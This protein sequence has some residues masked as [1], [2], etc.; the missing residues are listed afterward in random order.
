MPADSPLKDHAAE[1]RLFVVRTV[2]A[3]IG[4]A[5]LAGVLVARLGYLQIV[6]HDYYDTRSNDNRMRVQV[7][8]PVRGLIYDRNGVVL[9]DNLPAYRLEVVPEQ[10]EDLDAAIDRLSRYVEIREAD[11]KRFRQ[12]LAQSPNFRGIPIRLNLSQEEV[13]RFEVNRRKFPGMEIR[14]GLTRHYPLG[15]VAAHLIGYVGG[16]TER[17]MLTLDDKR[18]RGANHIGKTGVEYSYEELLHGY[19]GSRI[20]E[21]NAA[22]R[23]LREI[24]FNRPTPGHNLYLTVD[25]Q[26]Q[27]AAHEA[28]GDNDGAVVAIDPRTGGVLALVSRPGFDP[29]LFVDGISSKDYGNLIDNPHQPLFNR[30]LQGQY[31]PGSTIK[32]I[33]ALAA[34]E[35]DNIDP[36]R[37]IWSPGYITLPGSER[38]WRDWKREGHGWLDLKEAIFRSSDVYFYKLGMDLGI[39]VMHRFGTLF[40]LGRPTGI[41]LPRE[42][43]GLM[44]SREWKQGARN[45]TWYPGETLNTVI[46][47]GYM[48]AT[49]L[50]LA[51]MTA[52]IARRGEGRKPHV[53]MASEAPIDGSLDSVTTEPVQPIQLRDERHW[54][55]VIDAM[56]Q[57]VHAPRGTAHY[58][59]GRDI[60]YRMAGKTGTSQVRGMA[61]DEEAPDMEELA[62]KFRDHALFIGFAPLEEPR[63]AVAVLAE[64]GGSGGG[65]AAPIARKV[66]DAYL[67]DTHIARAAESQP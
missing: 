50:Q 24:E 28:L 17:E 30:A 6:E 2:L 39:D 15:E 18:Y 49:P 23:A 20:V 66:L 1:R 9:A 26:L 36:Q 46:G 42:R 16:I 37:Q 21:A 58:T 63:I 7:V 57:V 3:G 27:A 14:A 64:H 47:Q 11:R 51:H 8:P 60:P 59:M 53:L 19:P 31:P 29:D 52:L 13:A 41:D 33:M 67:T 12:R 56:R 61:Q 34:L 43:D 65:V 48:T 25:A 38:R 32:P 44:P 54:D 45:Q 5:V 55:I 62:Y 22:G 40:G 35:T 4:M 10:V